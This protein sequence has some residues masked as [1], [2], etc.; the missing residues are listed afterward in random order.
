[1]YILNKMRLSKCIYIFNNTSL[2]QDES[3]NILILTY[4]ESSKSLDSHIQYGH[5]HPVEEVIQN[6]AK[7]LVKHLNLS[8]TEIN[9]KSK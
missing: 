6:L 3:A 2:N 1:M 4:K 8:K 9:E 7:I 5:D